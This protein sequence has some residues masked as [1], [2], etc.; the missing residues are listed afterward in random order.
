MDVEVAGVD[1]VLTELKS[2]ANVGI[3]VAGDE[4]D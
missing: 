4:S 2:A 1:D 3:K